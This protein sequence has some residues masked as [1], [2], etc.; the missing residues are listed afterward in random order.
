MTLDN[1]QNETLEK[2]RHMISQNLLQDPCSQDWH[3][4][5][6]PANVDFC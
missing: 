6:F 4:Y 1:M 3:F 5:C 2:L